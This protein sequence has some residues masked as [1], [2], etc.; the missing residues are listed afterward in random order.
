[1]K[2]IYSFLYF[3]LSLSILAGFL[4]ILKRVL[5]D[6][7]SPRWQYGVRWLLILRALF[8]LMGTGRELTAPA[9]QLVELIKQLAEPSLRSV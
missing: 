7:L 4:L 8:P 3:T 2:S 9:L 1:M 5:R 6:K